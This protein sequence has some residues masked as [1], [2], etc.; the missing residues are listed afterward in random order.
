MSEINIYLCK[1]QPETLKISL[2]DNSTAR[3]P[4][5]PTSGNELYSS[6]QSISERS[7]VFKVSEGNTICIA[8]GCLCFH[9]AS[10]LEMQTRRS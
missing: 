5:L 10:L 1:V 4:S 8:Y 9:K 6:L 3:I 2:V 7:L